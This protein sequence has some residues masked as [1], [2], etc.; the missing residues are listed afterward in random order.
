[1]SNKICPNCKTTNS[2][3]N[4]K[5]IKCSENM[6]YV[7]N[8]K[9]WTDE[10]DKEGF[11]RNYLLE[12]FLT[13]SFFIR[14]LIGIVA[15]FIACVTKNPFYM[16]ITIVVVGLFFVPKENDYY[17]PDELF[18]FIYKKFRKEEKIPEVKTIKVEPQIKIES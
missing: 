4:L 17:N 9:V 11:T 7:E 10:Q 12:S 16:G 2:S 6:L 18:L 8:E 14:I 13:P 1:M 3:G 5:C 15:T